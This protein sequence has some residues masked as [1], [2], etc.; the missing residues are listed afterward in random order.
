MRHVS[1]G[2]TPDFWKMTGTVREHTSGGVGACLADK[3]PSAH[4]MRALSIDTIGYMIDV[5]GVTSRSPPSPS[6]QPALPLKGCI[7]ND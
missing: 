7:D 4:R 3:G 6:L 5:S 2:A 1:S